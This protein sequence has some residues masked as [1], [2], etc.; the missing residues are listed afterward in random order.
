MIPQNLL[1]RL[2]YTLLHFPSL[3]DFHLHL[4][5]LFTYTYVNCQLFLYPERGKTRFWPLGTKL[6]NP[7]STIINFYKKEEKEM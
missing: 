6:F 4:H 1:Y 2:Y 5:N 3:K 7:Y